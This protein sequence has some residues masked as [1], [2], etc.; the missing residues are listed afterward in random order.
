[1]PTYIEGIRFFF[2]EVEETAALGREV[3]VDLVLHTRV[4]LRQGI[5]GIFPVNFDI[6]AIVGSKSSGIRK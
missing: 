4:Q 2:K 5:G 1:M 6:L 3:V